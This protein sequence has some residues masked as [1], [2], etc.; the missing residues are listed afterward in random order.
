LRP[1][2]LPPP[3]VLAKRSSSHS[4][5]TAMQISHIDVLSHA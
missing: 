1:A 3:A 5:H 2:P 4:A